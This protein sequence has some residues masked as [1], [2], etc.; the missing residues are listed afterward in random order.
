M[1]LF[2]FEFK[3]VSLIS[4]GEVDDILIKYPF[5]LKIKIYRGISIFFYKAILENLNDLLDEELKDINLLKDMYKEIN[6]EEVGRK[7]F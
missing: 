5:L 6:K 2:A 4:E 7:K 3:D 1:V